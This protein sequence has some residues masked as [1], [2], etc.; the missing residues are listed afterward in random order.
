LAVICRAAVVPSFGARDATETLPFILETITSAY[1][2]A[3]RERFRELRLLA[4]IPVVHGRVAETL[5]QATGG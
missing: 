1:R 2:D 5:K 4:E 3:L